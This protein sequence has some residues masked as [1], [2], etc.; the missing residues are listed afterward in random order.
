MREIVLAD[1]LLDEHCYSL[2]VI[3]KHHANRLPL[4][5]AQHDSDCTILVELPF[6]ST[7]IA[8]HTPSARSPRTRSNT[9]A[10]AIESLSDSS[11]SPAVLG[12]S[13]SVPNVA[14]MPLAHHQPPTKPTATAN[15]SLPSAVKAICA[16][17]RTPPPQ[18]RAQQRVASHST[19]SLQYDEIGA[20]VGTF[21]QSLLS[22][23]MSG[24]PC[25]VYSGFK[26]D[27]LVAGGAI[28]SKRGVLPRG[29]EQAGKH[30]RIPFDATCYHTDST[31]SAPYVA[32]INL[33]DLCYRIPPKV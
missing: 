30:L 8:C 29:M 9:A 17:I 24:V 14:T 16:H 7:S 4:R 2:T 10:N 25:T 20:F 3:Y 19:P 15:K 18:R 26:A 5:D 22:G 1:L 6:T 12:S 21:Q 33:E 27:L 31:S 11:E 28:R 32:T 23:R 13:F